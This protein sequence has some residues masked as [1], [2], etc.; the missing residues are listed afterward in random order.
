[1]LYFQTIVN[2]DAQRRDTRCQKVY[3]EGALGTV[4]LKKA[5]GKGW[6]VEWENKLRTTCPACLEAEGRVTDD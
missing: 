6:R 1:M 5:E 4:A 3:S 2:C